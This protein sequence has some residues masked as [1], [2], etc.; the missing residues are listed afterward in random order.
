MMKIN[1]LGKLSVLGMAFASSV[2]VCAAPLAG[3]GAPQ[4]VTQTNRMNSDMTNQN[5][6]LQP[7]RLPLGAPDFNAI[8][9][10][11]YLPAIKEGISRQRAEIDKIVNNKEKA[12][13]QN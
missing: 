2:S 7:S 9:P 12:T 13:F 11:H 6:F 10:E 5:P 4:E 3:N 1:L 8:R